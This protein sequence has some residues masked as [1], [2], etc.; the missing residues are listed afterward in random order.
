MVIR[1]LALNSGSSKHGKA[2]RASVD[3]NCVVA[4]YLNST[5]PHGDYHEAHEPKL[6]QLKA[7]GPWRG[8]V[9]TLKDLRVQPQERIS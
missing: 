5:E 8:E 4:R 7:Y 6:Y 1:K 3:S 9:G 2:R